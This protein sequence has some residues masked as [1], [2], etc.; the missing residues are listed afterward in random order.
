M[1][2]T[3]QE[4]KGF[5]DVTPCTL[6]EGYKQLREDL[7]SPVSNCYTSTKLHGVATQK[8]V[9]LKCLSPGWSEGNH[10]T[11]L[12]AVGFNRHASRISQIR[13]LTSVGCKTSGCICSVQCK[14]LRL[15]D[16]GAV[17]SSV[18]LKASGY[19]CWVPD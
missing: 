1:S 5:L 4:E 9:K 11:H 16:A 19:I 8:T 17:V 2:I 6:G 10:K 3:Y 12:C 7:L 13:S 14:C 15:S 18:G